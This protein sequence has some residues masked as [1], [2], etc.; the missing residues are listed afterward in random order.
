MREIVKPKMQ[1]INK[2]LAVDVMKEC[3]RA[4]LGYD[5][6]KVELKK[7]VSL[8]II[9]RGISFH[10]DNLNSLQSNKPSSSRNTGV[11]Q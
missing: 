11:I 8:S 2:K 3:R 7:R 9:V 5:A 1:A 10:S 6:Y 4:G